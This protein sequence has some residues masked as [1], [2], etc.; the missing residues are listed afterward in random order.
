MAMVVVG[1]VIGV[2]VLGVLMPIVG[3]VGAIQIR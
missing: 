3:V 2:F 1:G